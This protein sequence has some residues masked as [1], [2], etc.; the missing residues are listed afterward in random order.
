[1]TRRSKFSKALSML[2]TVVLVIVASGPPVALAN[3][4]RPNQNSVDSQAGSDEGRGCR[5]GKL[6]SGADELS[7]VCPRGGS[8]SGV[9]GL[10]RRRGR[11]H[12]MRQGMGAGG[13]RSEARGANRP[14]VMQAT[15]ALVH[16]H[17][18]DIV[19]EIENIDDGVITVTRSP[20]NPEA[21]SVLQRHVREMKGL[22]E[23]GGRLRAWDPLFSE[24]F[25]HYAEIDMAV[26]ALD[27]GVRV[28]ETSENPEV[29]KL[30]Q[31]HARKV[32]EF[33]ARGPAAVHE[34]TPLPDDYRPG[35]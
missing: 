10:E 34:A 17:R 2:G 13:G 11:G 15:H 29:V 32:S 4:P 33:L 27:D 22:L 8:R 23:G 18:Q 30:I 28:I 24:V 14:E 19:R 21:V 20:G 6:A 12:T 25:K 3:D 5:C 9:D 26:E 1:M 31:A 35:E 16:E 7:G